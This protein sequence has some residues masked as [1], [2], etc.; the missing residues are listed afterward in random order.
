MAELLADG[1]CASVDLKPFSIDRFNRAGK[2]D[3][4]GRKKGTQVV[5]EQW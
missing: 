1:V 5:G 4:R 3:K 2:A